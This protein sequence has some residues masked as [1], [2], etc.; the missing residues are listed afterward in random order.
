MPLFITKLYIYSEDF[1]FKLFNHVQMQI[2]KN[3]N[4]MKIYL[5]LRKAFCVLKTIVTIFEKKNAENCRITKIDMCY[6]EIDF[7]FLY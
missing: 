5:K 3:E 1:N 6:Y 2:N 4:F 7:S